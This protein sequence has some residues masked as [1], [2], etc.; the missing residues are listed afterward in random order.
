MD[1]EHVVSQIEVIE[2]IEVN[3][4]EPYVDADESI[5]INAQLNTSSVLP[6]D[7]EWE[8]IGL[9][10]FE[11]VKAPA[12]F[13]PVVKF[14]DQ[15]DIDPLLSK[16][17]DR[18]HLICNDSNLT[19]YAACELHGNDPETQLLMSLPT[20]DGSEPDLS[21]YIVTKSMMKVPF[22]YADVVNLIP[23]W[24]QKYNTHIDQVSVLADIDH[25][26]WIV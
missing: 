1:P 5:F 14:L 4:F 9:E 8:V 26:T 21:R 7:E 17:K 12:L 24:D 19:M 15:Y 2:P 25:E 10:I 18:D 13:T 11:E 20:P 23:S 16:L 6:Y 22:S 3:P